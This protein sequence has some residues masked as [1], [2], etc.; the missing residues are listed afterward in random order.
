MGNQ[1]EVRLTANRTL[2]RLRNGDIEVLKQLYTDHFSACYLKISAAGGTLEECREVFQ[3]AL[4]S[5]LVKSSNPDFELS[6]SF[7]GYLVQSCYYL[8]LKSKKKL[9]RLESLL[10]QESL[11]APILVAQEEFEQREKTLLAIFKGLRQLTAACQN[12]LEGFF[13]DQRPDKDMAKELGYSKQFVKTKRQRCLKKLR[14]IIS[15]H[16]FNG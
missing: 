13:L 1:E 7:Q 6:S 15:K 2:D 3:E 11:L 12:V 14:E 9:K 8:W 5:L 4:Y 16:N 10:T